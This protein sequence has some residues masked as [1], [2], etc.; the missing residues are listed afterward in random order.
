[1][2]EG[3]RRPSKTAVCIFLVPV[4]R[5]LDRGR[6]RERRDMRGREG[7]K[8]GRGRECVTTNSPE[9][10]QTSEENLQIS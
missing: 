7:G 3:I 8:E 2:T 5:D 4:Y 10:R 6:G 9:A 1:M